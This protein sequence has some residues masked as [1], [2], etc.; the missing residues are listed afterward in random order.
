MFSAYI[1]HASMHNCYAIFKASFSLGIRNFCIG[2][3]HLIFISCQHFA[4]YCKYIVFHKLVNKYSSQKTNINF[5][6]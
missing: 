4:N 3:K 1:L 6:L 5:S 2:N